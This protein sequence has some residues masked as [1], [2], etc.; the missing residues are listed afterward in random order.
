MLDSINIGMTGLNGYA[1]GL[2][3]IANNTANLNTPGFK[4]STQQ[5][6]D[7]FSR[8]G[9]AG[10]L[11]GSGGS[12][13]TMNGTSLN[14][15][16]G[17][18]RQTGNALDL[19]VN[20]DGMFTLKDAQGKLHYTR[21]GQFSF[22]QAGDLVNRTDGAQVMGMDAAK[23][24]SSISLNALRTQVGKPTTSV[25]LSGNLSSTATDQTINGVT[26][27]DAAGVQ[28]S[29]T[30]NLKPSGAANPNSWDVTLLDGSTN[31]GSAKLV[32][33]GSTPSPA[34]VAMSYT[35][36]GQP[37]LKFNLD[38]S[39][40]VS[41][42]AAGNA[43]TLEVVNQDGFAAGDL[44]KASFDANG[45]LILSYTNG[46]T[47]KGLRLA[48]GRFDSPEAVTQIGGNEFDAI[49]PHAWHSG[50]AGAGGFGAISSGTL[51][52]SNVDLSQA[53]SELV[54]LQR[55]YQASSQIISTANDMLQELF[56]MK[57]K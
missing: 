3:V 22:N 53:F 35:P 2:R 41:S 30:L 47:V 9:S 50:V 46:Q 37:A 36:V 25:Q 38:F 1:Q 39:N 40:N 23:S 10:V 6:A 28:H 8:G 44:S 5:F 11:S 27:F 34:I 45:T 29:L 14:F 48:L 17:E 7:M 21:A 33:S 42:F 51:E 26:L 32:F 12:G 43:S 4:A 13:L 56:A 16:Q 19:A 20:G 55:G 24:L 15:Q 57:S 52:T 18:M 49:D 54:I 31:V